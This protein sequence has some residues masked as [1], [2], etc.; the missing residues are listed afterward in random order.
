MS[1]KGAE[2]DR[3]REGWNE[4]GGF[5]G[6]LRSPASI[7]RGGGCMS[8]HVLARTLELGYHPRTGRET[9]AK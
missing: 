3:S 8:C 6:D 4:H 9:A 7:I 2:L 1:R 5:G